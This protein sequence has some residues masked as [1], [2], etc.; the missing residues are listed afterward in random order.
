MEMERAMT[1]LRSAVNCE[2]RLVREIG[3]VH[4]SQTH[5]SDRA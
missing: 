3:G 2:I 4:L 1:G 5:T